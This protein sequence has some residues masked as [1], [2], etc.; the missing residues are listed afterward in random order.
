MSEKKAQDVIFLLQK[1]NAVFTGSFALK[2]YG[3]LNRALKDIDLVFSTIDDLK[4]FCT[5]IGNQAEPINSKDCY[6][7][8]FYQMTIEGV[9]IDCF[10]RNA[11]VKLWVKNGYKLECASIIW[12]KKLQVML[13]RSSKKDDVYLKHLADFN[14]YF[15]G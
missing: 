1:N 11:P 13:D 5:N 4:I 12:A 14:Y 6:D 10:I 3:M 8:D 15:Q 9:K 2:T 7:D